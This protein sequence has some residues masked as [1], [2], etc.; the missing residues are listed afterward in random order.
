MFSDLVSLFSGWYLD[1]VRDV[2]VV[3]ELGTPPDVFL[4]EIWSAF[5]PWEEIIAVVVLVT[6]I[7]CTFKLLRSL[8]CKIL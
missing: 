5:V 7:I 4:P 6:F 8:L 1:F 2:K 3:L